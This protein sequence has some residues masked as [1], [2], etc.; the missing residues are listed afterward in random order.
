MHIARPHRGSY[1]C[2]STR[3]VVRCGR[4]L[5]YKIERTRKRSFANSRK[6]SRRSLE[7]HIDPSAR[8]ESGATGRSIELSENESVENDRYPSSLNC[9]YIRRAET[10]LCSSAQIKIGK[11]TRGTREDE[12][13]SRRPHHNLEVHTSRRSEHGWRLGRLVRS[14]KTA[15]AATLRE[16]S[17]SSPHP[18][19]RSR[20]HC[21]LQTVDGGGRRTCRAEG[22]TPNHFLIG[23]SCGA[24]AAGH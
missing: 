21:Q 4:V 2:S 5:A 11:H 1:M 7:S 19:A 9:D 12:E 8:V 13:R 20:A 23:R 10:L 15:L 16:P 3:K 6:S 14:V 17:R 24:A 18:A 22:L